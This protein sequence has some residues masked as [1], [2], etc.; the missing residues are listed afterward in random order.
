MCSDC[1]TSHHRIMMNDASAT[2]TDSNSGKRKAAVACRF[3][4]RPGKRRASNACCYCRARKVR[5]DMVE[6]G[7]SCTN[8][9]L[10]QVKC[11]MTES[12]RRTFVTISAES[13]KKGGK[14]TIV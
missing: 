1:P 6:N 3:V 8:C 10:D 5:C 7:S 2:V 14:V 11:V 13:R 12:K 9:R 4:R